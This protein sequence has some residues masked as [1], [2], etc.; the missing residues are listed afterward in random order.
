MLLDTVSGSLSA[1][2]APSELVHGPNPRALTCSPAGCLAGREHDVWPA[3]PA[4]GLPCGAAGGICCR[5]VPSIHLRRRAGTLCLQ[6]LERL[7]EPSGAQRLT[8]AR[9]CGAWK[10]WECAGRAAA[11]LSE[12]RTRV[13]VQHCAWG[14][15]HAGQQRAHLPAR[16]AHSVCQSAPSPMTPAPP[17][18][19]YC[20]PYGLCTRPR[21]GHRPHPA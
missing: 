21:A 4:A 12:L 11:A 14:H 18:C 7:A 2:R 5:S 20:R 6:G 3:Q 9:L 10:R 8:T 16:S 13:Q 17:C 19:R 1:R 15:P